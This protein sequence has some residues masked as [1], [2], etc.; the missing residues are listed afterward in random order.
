MNWLD[1]MRDTD[2]LLNGIMRV[3]HPEQYQMGQQSKQAL[4]GHGV[5][6]EVLLHW[7]SMFDAIQ[8][9]SNRESPTHRDQNSLAPWYDMLLTVGPYTNGIM[10]MPSIGIKLQYN[11]GTIV[12]L[13]GRLVSHG[14]SRVDGERVCIAY[15]MRKNV[16]ER[17]GS[18][19]ATWSRGPNVTKI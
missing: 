3:I 11:P 9:I 18:K 12:A 4:A 6:L 7:N 8:V 16:Q 13:S 15:F 10:K 1:S 19:K 14:V 17:L 5:D 2:L